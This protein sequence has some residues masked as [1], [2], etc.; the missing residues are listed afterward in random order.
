MA[1]REVDPQLALLCHTELAGGAE[2]LA[3]AVADLPRPE[4]ERLLSAL[5]WSSCWTLRTMP[6]SKSRACSQ[7]SGEAS[8]VIRSHRCAG[9]EA[10]SPR[11]KTLPVQFLADVFLVALDHEPSREQMR[12]FWNQKDDDHPLDEPTAG[13]RCW[14]GATDVGEL[15]PPGPA[16]AIGA[17]I[18]LEGTLPDYCAP[19]LTP[20]LAARILTEYEQSIIDLMPSIEREQLEIFLTQHMGCHLI[21]QG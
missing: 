13:D 3:E 11:C 5:P 6:R 7:A 20:D 12:L 16:G 4:L 9:R 18:L 10:G 21:T 14:L 8:A 2:S 17:L 19:R 15:R 1:P